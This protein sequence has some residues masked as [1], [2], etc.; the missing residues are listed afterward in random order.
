[1][2][3]EFYK[4]DSVDPKKNKEV[5][6]KASEIIKSGGLVA[7]PTETVYGLGASIWD[8]QALKK[9]Y[10][11][12]GRPS[13]NPLIAHIAS[14]DSLYDLTDFVSEKAKI[15]ID[16]FWPG[17]LTLIFKRKEGIVDEL[18]GGLDTVAVRFPNCL[19]SRYLIEFSG[20]LA[21]P[22]ANT[23][24]KPSPTRASHVKYDLDGK[25]DMIIDGG[26]CAFGI[27]ST[28]V[29]VSSEIP[30]LLRPGIV[31]LEQIEK[32]VGEIEVD[33]AVLEKLEDDIKPKAPGMK[34]KHYSP[35]ADITIITGDIDKVSKEI[36]RLANKV[37]EET[38][39]K[40]GILATDQ[41]IDLYDKDKFIV[42]NLG[43]RNNIETISG[44]LFKMLRKFDYFMVDYVFAEGF[45]ES[46]IGLAVM[47]RLKKAAGYNVISLQ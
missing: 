37:F 15:L 9:I 10:K 28:I 25:I 26:A 38:G 22:S 18:T 35:K 17:P 14:I 34:Y 42:L 33:P 46:E 7:F 16:N 45:G 24:G 43:N 1:M 20:A 27:E 5:F 47:N 44:N 40:V 31:T 6:I 30:C 32:L 8:P 41:T 19:V 13:D 39:K 21:A 2:I 4:V 3:T 36:V 11:A 23:S 12:K 29:D